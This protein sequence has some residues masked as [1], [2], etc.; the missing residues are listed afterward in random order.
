MYTQL[1]L[2]FSMLLLTTLYYTNHTGGGGNNVT[3]STF[4]INFVYIQRFYDYYFKSA[5][6]IFYYNYF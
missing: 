4:Y 3:D 1:A 5:G 6:V 2:D